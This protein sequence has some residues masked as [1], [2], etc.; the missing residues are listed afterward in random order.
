MTIGRVNPALRLD[1]QGITGLGSVHYNLIEP[2]LIEA[3]LQRGEGGVERR[4]RGVGA[5]DDV[6]IASGQISQ[7]EDCDADHADLRGREDGGELGVAAQV[8]GNAAEQAGDL[9]EVAGG[10]DG[11]RLDVEGVHVARGADGLGEAGGVASFAG[12]A[13]D[14]D[15]AGAQDFRREFLGAFGD[16]DRIYGSHGNF[17]KFG[18]RFSFQAARPS[19]PSSER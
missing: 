11:F 6:G 7:V 13:V 8:H 16:A 18:A 4:L 2:A 3:A 5:R 12:R 9:E 10:G 1:E 15:V 19:S 14:G 17:R